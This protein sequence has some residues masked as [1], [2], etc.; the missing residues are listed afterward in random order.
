[1]T[2]TERP[3][4][5][6]I[7]SSGIDSRNIISSSLS[8]GIILNGISYKI[9]KQIARSGES[10]I[11]LVSQ[12]ESN[13]IFKYYYTQFK[14]KDKILTKLKGLKHPD[15]ICL[16]DYGYYEQRF[17]EISEY[18]IGGTL[19]EISPVRTIAKIKEIVS[20]TIEAL[21]YC[22]SH[23]IIHRDIK[24]ENIFYKTP[25]KKDIAI[26]DFGIASSINDGQE[27]VLTTM[28]RTNLY[29]APELF[30]SIRG[31]TLI[32]KSIDYYALGITLLHLWFGRNPFEN[33][34]E[35][36]VM[37]LKSEGRIVFPNDIDHEAE[38]LIKGLLT[39]NPRDRWAYEEVKRWLKGEEVKV[40]YQTLQFEYRPYSFGMIGTE[41]V[42]VNNPKDLAFYLEKYPDKGEGHLYR[43]TIA[44]WIEPVD[45][46]L[47]NDLMDIVEKDYPLDKTA[48]LTKAIYILDPEKPFKALNNTKLSTQGD[49][50]LHFEHNFEYYQKEL[51]N[52]NADFYLFLEAR[53]YKDKAY[54][55]R[56]YFTQTNSEAALNILILKLQG[57][58]KL[59]VDKYEIYQPEELLKVDD[60]T[61]AK[62]IGQLRNINSKLSIWIAGFK[63]LQPSI[64][65]WR[66][67]K[68]YDNTTLRYA[69]QKGYQFSIDLELLDNEKYKEDTNFVHNKTE[70]Y[71]LFKDNYSVFSST[72]SL[73]EEANYW[74]VNYVGS[75]FYL[76]VID[77]LKLEKCPASQFK[78]LFDYALLYY[79]DATTNIYRVIENLLPECSD[80]FSQLSKE[81][82]NKISTEI[83]KDIEKIKE[84]EKLTKS[85]Y[86]DLQDTISRLET[87][88]PDLP[89]IK[90][91][92]KK[93][94]QIKKRAEEIKQKNAL[95]NQE[96][97]TILD[98]KYD[99]IIKKRKKALKA[100]F[101]FT[102][103]DSAYNYIIFVIGF[104]GFL[105]GI[106]AAY[107]QTDRLTTDFDIFI[108]Y[109]FGAI[110]WGIIGLVVGWV[111]KM[112]VSETAK[113]STHHR[114]LE[115]T[116][117][118]VCFTS[119]EQIA[120]DESKKEI[121]R[122]FEEKASFEVY[123][124]IVCILSQGQQY[125]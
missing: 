121:D 10:E 68:R 102:W 8:N 104:I 60:K 76:I 94:T 45:P 20:Q 106:F 85:Y 75:S 25:D 26:G 5:D 11:F 83:Y 33:T 67:L 125:L 43:N 69:L 58:E 87:T 39:V 52:P 56:G 88:N 48:G 80:S 13:F 54:E 89:I 36:S 123:Q 107:G 6:H 77:Y 97:T 63:Y 31:K 22:H 103:D 79:K 116:L 82:N 12:N 57:V 4:Q 91:I 110:I 122:Y 74:L 109:V 15:I 81:L 101:T 61:K 72:P 27:D 7:I 95:E 113:A 18:A 23:G 117:R 37:R 86:S 44:K 21:N 120:K 70:F 24:P 112:I 35:Y 66:I 124:E 55:Y 111:I 105:F 64:D 115:E 119:H 93:L 98:N 16:I 47:F 29:A 38:K 108:N 49:I 17:F 59:I 19:Q 2:N 84:D 40:N 50:S 92:N 34:D 1:M 30:S 99:E 41:Q 62:V 32:E 73:I 3:L 90:S 28:A 78:E 65:K 53:G 46:G 114:K 118:K 100:H 96:K 14:P 51:Q 71:T 9:V 42:V